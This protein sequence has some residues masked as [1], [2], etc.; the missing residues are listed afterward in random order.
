MKGGKREG[1]GRPRADTVIIT[2][3]LNTRTAA[4]LRAIIPVGKRS[5]FVSDAVEELL[6][7]KE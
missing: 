4:R 7:V 1:A 3:K 2:L 6:R 5:E